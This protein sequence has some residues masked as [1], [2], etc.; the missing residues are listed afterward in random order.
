MTIF[1]NLLLNDLASSHLRTYRPLSV[2][3]METTI[4]C[5]AP[6][7]EP[8][9]MRTARLRKFEDFFLPS[10]MATP[11][12]IAICEAAQRAAFATGARWTAMGRGSDSAFR[13]DGPDEAA[14]ALGFKPKVSSTSWDHE[15][16]LQGVYRYWLSR[17]N[18]SGGAYRG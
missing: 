11:D 1:P 18:R 5:I 15:I 14:Q 10:G 9:D 7:G 8:R 12:D 16:A 17:V 13:V 3:R 4:W 2:D 6:V